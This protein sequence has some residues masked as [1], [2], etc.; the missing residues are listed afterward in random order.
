[1]KPDMKTL[2]FAAL[3]TVITVSTGSGLAQET[4]AQLKGGR[5]VDLTHDFSSDTVYWPTGEGF[6][7][8]KVFEGMTGEGFYAAA[9]KFTAE[10][11]GGTHIDAPVHFAKG[12]QTLEQI[13]IE[14]LIGPAV[15]IDVS[16]KAASD[17]DYLI[18]VADFTEWES[19]NG[20][21][22]EGSIVLLNTG[23]AKYWPDKMKYMGTDKKGPDA[24]KELHF[25]GLDPAA[26]KW[27]T[28]QR[29]ISAIGLDTPSIDY[30]QSAL[31]ESHRILFDKNIPAFEN[32][33]NLDMLPAKGALVVALPMK[34]KGGSG[35]PLRIVALIPGTD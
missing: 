33:A 26:A 24:V 20:R 9:N 32:V 1:M 2:L 28:E 16:Q 21:I 8:E 6:R 27:L 23:Y 35:G 15:V 3:L 11:H 17:R 30:G 34:I 13:P 14:N 4:A 31:F 5:W 22:P 19:V 7:L 29:S 18:G 10:E 12:G 25:P